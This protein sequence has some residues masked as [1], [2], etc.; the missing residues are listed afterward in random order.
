LNDYLVASLLVVGGTNRTITPPAGWTLLRRTND[1]TNIGIATYTRTGTGTEAATYTWTF[2]AAAQSAGAM[3]AYSGVGVS[4]AVD[5]DLGNTIDPGATAQPTAALTLAFTQPAGA[6]ADVE[7]IVAFYAVNSATTLSTPGGTALE[8]TDGS[9]ATKFIAVDTTHASPGT[10]PALT[11]TAGAAVVGVNEALAL[12]PASVFAINATGGMTAGGSA[13]V[14]TVANTTAT[15]GI[16]MGGVAPNI[17]TINVSASGGISMSGLA[18]I[19]LVRIFASPSNQNNSRLKKFTIVKYGDADPGA[20]VP[21]GFEADAFTIR[22]KVAT[23]QNKTITGV[24]GAVMTDST[25]SNFA[26]QFGGV[27]AGDVFTDVTTNSTGFITLVNGNQL[28][29]PGVTMNPGDQYTIS[30][31]SLPMPISFKPIDAPA[32][33]PGTPGYSQ[34]AERFK[35]Y[36]QRPSVTSVDGTNIILAFATTA[37]SGSPVP[38]FE[39][40][41]ENPHKNTD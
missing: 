19:G 34:T 21:H 28:T 18:V 30:Q 32:T 6:T 26:T 3:L 37:G 31:P 22:T 10:Q 16:T 33:L 11:S 2:D 7:K 38:Q 25:V 13:I 39:M 27:V 4:A 12:S 9:T 41:C 35:Y 40:L 15:G 5:T 23:S 36:V 20:V 8:A 1:A 17:E 14:S 29:I 24:A